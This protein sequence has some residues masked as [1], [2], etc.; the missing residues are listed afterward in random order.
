MNSA[1]KNKTDGTRSGLD[2]IENN[3]THALPL[4]YHRNWLIDLLSVV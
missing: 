4:A 2:M 1:P 3:G